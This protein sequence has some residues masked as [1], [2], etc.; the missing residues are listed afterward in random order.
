[1]LLALVVAGSSA[2]AGA[3]VDVEKRPVPDYDGRG[4]PPTAAGDVL[5][6]VPRVIVSPLWLVSEF[7]VRR[8]LGVLVTAIESHNVV[9]RVSDVLGIGQ[10]I[11]LVPT[12]YYDLSVHPHFGL[13]FFWDGFLFASNALRATASAGVDYLAATVTDRVTLGKELILTLRYNSSSRSDNIFY[14]IGSE[15]NDDH[16]SRYEMRRLEGSAALDWGNVLHRIHVEGGERDIRF[17][18]DS[19]CDDPSLAQ[20][21]ATGVYP[22]PFGFLDGGYQGPYGRVRVA[23]D[24]RAQAPAT[25][26]GVIFDGEIGSDL[27]HDR[28][29]FRGGGSIGGSIDV[30][31]SR[32]FSLV[33]GAQFAEPLSG[34]DVPFTELVALGGTGPLA[35]FPA[36][37]LVGRSDAYA[38]VS[39][40][41]PVWSYLVGVAHAGVGNVFGARL[42]DF[43]VDLLRFSTGIG[44]RSIGP[45]DHRFSFQIAF[46]T[47]PFDLGFKFD[48]IALVIGGVTGF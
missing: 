38:V 13:Y 4:D 30:H 45:P 15:I 14:G 29:W 21:V 31:A 32:V 10:P 11:G 39:Y 47:Q 18:G 41:W 27:A 5:I 37:E 33:V 20:A 9:E 8:P 28:S 42:E 35:A 25:G 36:G 24:T 19:C 12:F 17:G 1:L 7:V 2:P 46:G 22:F 48:S 40:E 43:D 26:V 44:L 34:E 16:R 23:L 6:W 3:D